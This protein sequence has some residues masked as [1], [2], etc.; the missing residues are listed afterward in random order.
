ML[1]ILL[2]YRSYLLDKLDY[3]YSKLTIYI[4]IY[5]QLILVDYSSITGTSHKYCHYI[6]V[7]A[8]QL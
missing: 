1:I 4:Y 8:L 6:K 2:I 7:S 5:D 3:D